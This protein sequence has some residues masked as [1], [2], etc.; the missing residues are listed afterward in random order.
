[1]AYI[2]RDALNMA[3]T[4]LRF[5]DDGTLRHWD[6]RQNWCMS[7]QEVEDLINSIPTADVTE[8]NVGKWTE[9]EVIHKAEAKDII[10]EWQSCRCSVCA[11]YDTRPYLYVFDE[12]HYC[13]WCGAK[14]DGKETEDEHH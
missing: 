8:R 7:R 2:D 5:N 3:F 6:D 1:M 9:K 14:M 10:E 11:R 12:P 4:M 13:S